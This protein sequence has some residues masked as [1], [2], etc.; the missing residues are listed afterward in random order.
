MSNFSCQSEIVKAHINLKLDLHTGGASKKSEFSQKLLVT[1]NLS[2]GQKSA[3]L[4]ER[5]KGN[6]NKN[7]LGSVISEYSAKVNLTANFTLAGDGM[8]PCLKKLT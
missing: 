7:N 1:D 2:N 4:S 5:K 6:L 8:R 3:P